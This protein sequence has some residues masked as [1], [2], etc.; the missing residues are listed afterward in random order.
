MD[1]VLTVLVTDKMNELTAQWK[2][3]YKEEYFNLYSSPDIFRMIKWRWMRNA[4]K[5]KN[6]YS[7]V[8]GRSEGA[9]P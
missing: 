6:A 7:V 9:R 4:G 2:K 8:V 5:M 3:W 1:S